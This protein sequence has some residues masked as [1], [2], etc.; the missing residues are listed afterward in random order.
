MKKVRIEVIKM[1]LHTDLMEKYEV[2][3]IHSCSMELGQNFVSIDALKPDG[4]CESA[5]NNLFPYVFAFANGA[6][7]FYD[8]W[9]INKNQAIISCNDGIR[10]VSFLLEVIE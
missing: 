3:N 9:M 2:K 7:N 6:T 1:Q 8:N 10:P 4:M 5:W